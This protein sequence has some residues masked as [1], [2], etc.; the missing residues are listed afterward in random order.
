M[1]RIDYVCSGHELW[2][3]IPLKYG[4]MGSLREHK[5]SAGEKIPCNVIT[6]CLYL[7]VS[8]VEHEY[9]CY[10]KYT[11]AKSIELQQL[12]TNEKYNYIKELDLSLDECEQIY[13]N[14]IDEVCKEER[15]KEEKRQR[16]EKEYIKNYDKRLKEYVY[17]NQPIY[18]NISFEKK[19]TFKKWGCK[20]DP[21][22]KKWYVTES[23]WGFNYNNRIA[24]FNRMIPKEMYAAVKAGLV[25][26]DEMSRD[27]RIEYKRY[28]K[29]LLE[30]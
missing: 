10:K 30:R 19:D 6:C 24:F 29:N 28:A 14:Y 23:T 21:N 9:E 12:F 16:E 1:N 26:I 17:S 7:K 11:E 5:Y 4:R 3:S 8:E 22:K 13:C 25:S 18:M 2:P 20:Y 15:L 27:A